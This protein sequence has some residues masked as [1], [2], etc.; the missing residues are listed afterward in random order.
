MIIYQ[1]W[2]KIVT[3]FNNSENLIDPADPI[4]KGNRR[5]VIE[6]E[7]MNK[8]GQRFELKF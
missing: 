4:L 8:D 2:I 7:Y 6:K 5:K 1:M 3:D